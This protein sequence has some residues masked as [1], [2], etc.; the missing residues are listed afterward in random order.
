M[1]QNVWIKIP[2]FKLGIKAIGGILVFRGP[3]SAQAKNRP[4]NDLLQNHLLLVFYSPYLSGTSSLMSNI[5][6]YYVVEY[7]IHVVESEVRDWWI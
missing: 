7:M 1:G 5:M 6:Y 3:L 2:N 4:D